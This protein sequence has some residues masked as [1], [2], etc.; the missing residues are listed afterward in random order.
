MNVLK[1]EKKW[2]IVES[3]VDAAVPTE[4]MIKDENFK[5]SSVKSFGQSRLNFYA[6]D[7]SRS[8]YDIPML[9]IGTAAFGVS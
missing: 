5:I 6:T 3:V 2:N 4:K 9:R 1:E 7:E 8:T